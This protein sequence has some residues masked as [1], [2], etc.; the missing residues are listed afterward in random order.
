MT[1]RAGGTSG[2]RE[3]GAAPSSD[4]PDGLVT[5]SGKAPA[6]ARKASTGPGPGPVDLRAA[7]RTAQAAPS[8]RP[9]EL[10]A[11]VEA[12]LVAV[13]S[14]MGAAGLPVIGP[15]EEPLWSLVEPCSRAVR[16]ARGTLAER[17]RSA[18]GLD[19][20]R[21]ALLAAAAAFLDPVGHADRAYGRPRLP[22]LL[23]GPDGQVPSGVIDCEIECGARTVRWYP[24]GWKREGDLLAIVAGRPAEFRYRW[25]D[26]RTWEELALD[27]II[28]C[29]GWASAPKDLPP[30]LRQ[31]RALLAH[32][33]RTNFATGTWA[34]ESGQVVKWLVRSGVVSVLS[35]EVG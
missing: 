19:D 26:K 3:L 24:E 25:A 14:A 28:I 22:V 16:T 7:V 8:R 9:A 18:R 20:A 31:G 21:H 35:A 17:G 6:E 1:S 33:L 15:D 5:V 12:L 11:G 29:C 27:M 10:R 23:P 30:A 4:G 34:L 13:T 32:E 2:G